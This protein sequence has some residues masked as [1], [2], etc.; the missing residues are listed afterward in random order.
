M[1]VLRIR[2]EDKKLIGISAL[3]LALVAV[4]PAIL[5]LG[6]IDLGTG[7]TSRLVAVLTFLGVLVTASVSL[8]GL[9]TSHQTERRLRLEQAEEDQRLKLD[10]AMRAGQLLTPTES[11]TA[12]PAAVASGLLALTKLDNAHL[13]VALLVDLWTDRTDSV[14][15]EV[16][17]LVIDAA[18]RSDSDGAQLIAA[19]L[20]CRNASRLNACQSLDWPSAIEG[21][22]IPGLSDRAK[23]LLVEALTTM[24]LHTPANESALRAI[25]V[26]LY[27]IWRYDDDPRVRGCVGKLI[28][29]LIHRLDKLGYQDFMQGNQR[30]ML[31]D[32]VTA[33]KSATSNPDGYL[34]RMSTEVARQ[35]E[36]WANKCTGLP[37]K[38]GA[39]A[40]ADC[41][42]KLDHSVVVPH[43]VSKTS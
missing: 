19:E 30:V 33:A 1:A 26:R 31:D 34:N 40:T 6:P 18:L 32:L 11:A 22:W 10:A 29:A 38:S 2:D 27:G 36:A 23:L 43:E 37:T 25:A 9:M 21:C 28:N 39:L 16:A 14:S 7:D 41:G 35:L 13:A 15:N 5:L 24:T 12:P 20:L 17:V 3:V 8:V 4:V 42:G